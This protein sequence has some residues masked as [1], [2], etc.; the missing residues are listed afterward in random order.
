MKPIIYFD[1]DR[2]IFNMDL[3]AQDLYAVF[4]RCG[5]E[6]EVVKE[7]EKTLSK[8]GYTFTAH[9]KALGESDESSE[10]L[11]KELNQLL[12]RGD[13]YL[14][15][16]VL[17]VV[18]KMHESGYTLRL[19]SFGTPS[20]QKKKWDGLLLLQPFFTETHFVHQD[21][22]KADVLA[23]ETSSD[24]AVYLVDDSSQWLVEAD[25]KAPWVH[26][27][28][29]LRKDIGSTSDRYEGDVLED[30]NELLQ[31]VQRKGW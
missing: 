19:I 18:K 5:Y 29:M 26:C 3:Y 7:A 25:Q 2:T 24:Q 9:A 12:K 1:L 15:S 10:V 27:V 31:L 16:D 20:Y 28:Q 23:R 4:E 11:L 30:F 14:F 22:S 17:S 21:E 13:D 6:Y 8:T